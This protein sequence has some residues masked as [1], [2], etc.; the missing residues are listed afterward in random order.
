MLEKLYDAL[1]GFRPEDLCLIA[2]APGVGKSTLMMNI[3]LDMINSGKKVLIFSLELSKTEFEART[4]MTSKT[5]DTALLS[6]VDVSIDDDFN[7]TPNTIRAIIEKKNPDIVFI[8]YL[9]LMSDD[10]EVSS[11]QLEM[12][13]VTYK[14]S[15][16]AKDLNTPII[17]L[18]Q[19]S[20]SYFYNKE[21]QKREIWR[22]PDLTILRNIGSIEQ[23]LRQIIFIHDPEYCNH[24]REKR[25]IEII[26]AKNAHGERDVIFHSTFDPKTGGFTL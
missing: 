22:R 24:E 25:I 7:H 3:A 8:D 6:V 21:T 1:Y 26:I 15:L 16:I 13:N 9:Q 11:R 19:L 2:G 5:Y 23:D 4:N 10:E 12:S 18:S 14:L 20:S 17:V